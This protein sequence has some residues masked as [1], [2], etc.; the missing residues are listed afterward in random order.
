MRKR[1]YKW[2]LEL[3]LVFAIFLEVCPTEIGYLTAFLIRRSLGMYILTKLVT[4]TVI[5]LPLGVYI[6]IRKKRGE[7]RTIVWTWQL[8]VIAII[9]S[10]NLLKDSVVMVRWFLGYR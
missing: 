4:L 2:L 8:T 1:R 7:E 9:V 6:Y 5:L 3:S 10:I